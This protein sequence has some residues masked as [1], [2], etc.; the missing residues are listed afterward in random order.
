MSFFRLLNFV[1]T[2]IMNTY[3]MLRWGNA[4]SP[5]P[6]KTTEN[7]GFP[8]HIPVRMPPQSVV[9]KEVPL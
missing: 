4:S 8:P 1:I 7:K 3:K 2:H 9:A 5:N 6:V